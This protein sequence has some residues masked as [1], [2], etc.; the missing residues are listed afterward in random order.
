MRDKG[1][2]KTL[3]YSLR[4]TQIEIVKKCLFLSFFN[5]K[6]WQKISL[7]QNFYV[8]LQRQ[9]K[10]MED[11]AMTTI[12]IKRTKTFNEISIQCERI[13]TLHISQGYGTDKMFQKCET[14]FF[15]VL[16]KNGGY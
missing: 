1:K 9:I 10:T 2:D 8:P 16:K 7:Y 4:H 15:K 6:N 13:F 5:E 11:K 14:I 12:T 3:K